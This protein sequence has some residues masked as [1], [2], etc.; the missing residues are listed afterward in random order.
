MTTLLKW[1][2]LGLAEKVEIKIDSRDDRLRFEK[3]SGGFSFWGQ[4]RAVDSKGYIWATP[5]NAFLEDEEMDGMGDLYIAIDADSECGLCS[6]V[7]GKLVSA[8]CIIH[9]SLKEFKNAKLVE[10]LF[11]KRLELEKEKHETRQARLPRSEDILSR[12]AARRKELEIELNGLSAQEALA[13]KTGVVTQDA[14]NNRYNNSVKE[15]N[16]KRVKEVEARSDTGM[17]KG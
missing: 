10:A 2:K 6:E 8:R 3:D 16:A 7:Y 14:E 17:K 4:V 11:A 12:Y 1:Q 13:V 15:L 5:D 9:L